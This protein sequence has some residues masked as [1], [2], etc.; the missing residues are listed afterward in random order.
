MVDNIKLPQGKS[1]QITRQQPT[2]LS[3]I[4]NADFVAGLFPNVPPGTS[5]A[6]CSKPNNPEY[7]GWIARPVGDV[8][9]QCPARNN[10]FINCSIL[11]VGPD[12]TLDAKKS[13]VASLGF[14]LFDDVGTKVPMDA[15][16]PLSPT[17]L[18]ETSPGNFQATYVIDPPI[19]DLATI[20]AVQAAVSAA[21]LGD[22]GAFGAS[23]WGRMPVGINGKPKHTNE[24][25]EPFQCRLAHYEP[26][27]RYTLEEF[28]TSFNLTIG[29]AP[30]SANA[31]KEG[32]PQ[33]VT[34]PGDAVY[35]PKPPENG[36]IMALKRLG[37][38]KREI[39]LGKADMT[40]PWACEHTGELDT[41]AAYFA[42][43]DQFPSGGF[44]CQHSHGD[45]LSINHLIDHLGI[46]EHEA[47]DK[48][49]I[50]VIP[51][52]LNRV[53]AA[54][55]L[56]LMARGEH[57]QKGGL[58][59]SIG[60]D[61]NTGDVKIVPTGEPAL[62][63]ALA[64]AVDFEKMD[65]RNKA[66]WVR[67]NPPAWHVNLL[68]RA[69]SYTH[70]PELE[71]L[72]RQPY[73]R[74]TDGKLV[75]QPGY[76]PV[77]KMYGEFDPADFPLPEPTEKA[78]QEALGRIRHLL[79]EFRFNTEADEATAI[80]AILTAVVRPTLSIAPGFHTRA[81]SMSSGKSTLNALIGL[82]AGPGPNVNV[83]YPYQKDEAVKVI[84][85]LLM[86]G[87]AVID[88]DDMEHDWFAHGI[89]KRLF[90][91]PTITDRILGVSKTA[92]VG[93][94]ALFLGSGNNVGPQRDLLRRVMV[95]NLNAR[96]DSAVTIEYEGDPLETMRTNRG[97]LVADAIT[98]LRA[99][100]HAGKPRL[101]V[102]NLASYGKQWADYGRHPL[103]WLGLPDPAA[104]LFDQIRH[105]PDAD[106]LSH[107][108][109]A[110]HA[111]FGTAPMTVRKVLD[112]VAEKGDCDLHDAL[113]E[114]PFVE[115]EEINR[116][117][118]GGYLKRNANRIVDGLVLEKAASTER[119]AWRVVPVDNA[120]PPLPPL[121]RSPS[122]VGG[123]GERDS[124]G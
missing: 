42:P 84:L 110:W 109:S 91:N 25:G 36:V 40:C 69:E 14:L 116:S 53:I 44:C 124:D 41:G 43:S 75:T 86:T 38:Y 5:P 39:S 66:K 55:E 54:C 62:F 10:N 95:I 19:T 16:E 17:S 37:L 12:G 99:W 32:A 31:S 77:S 46:S 85:A 88:F 7:G 6:I 70:L 71:G 9:K 106:N 28:S 76:D 50:R 87:P 13:S 74:E 45:R 48:A 97:K 26:L 94:R 119:N 100:Q 35:L 29:R 47:R 105:D 60:K 21:K 3:N 93:T 22:P 117:K 107:L 20:K 23:S 112:K 65:N 27:N 56:A 120:L 82:F 78:A 68:S 73:F 118:M 83:S 96:T 18:V 98:I 79:R 33:P 90:T 102:P 63:K 57:Y 58:I 101:P 114:L 121:P 24:N 103:T 113:L 15:L 111:M 104:G 80:A 81:P 1:T 2:T 8:N 122:Q 89:I 59:V 52:E 11:K 49:R 123:N 64:A 51:G 72:A 92:T 61:P 34:L 4:S 108:L 67:C 115:R 30:T